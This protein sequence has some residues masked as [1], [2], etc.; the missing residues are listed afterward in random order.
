MAIIT[1]GA[2]CRSPWLPYGAVHAI[3]LV[4][5]HCYT[6]FLNRKLGR[7]GF[8]TCNENRWIR[9]AATV[10][11]FGYCAASMIFFANTFAQIGEIFSVLR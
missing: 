2:T 11:T 6:L 7:E 4:V 1:R 5:N 8:K 9:A 3:A 10:L